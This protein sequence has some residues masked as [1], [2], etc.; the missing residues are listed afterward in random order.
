MR[1]EAGG[2]SQEAGVGRRESRARV[3]KTIKIPQMLSASL[4]EI[5]FKK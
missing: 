3:N 4:A 5:R 1:R 2:E